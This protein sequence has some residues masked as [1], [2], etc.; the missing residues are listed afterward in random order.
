[1]NFN[2]LTPN[3]KFGAGGID[4]WDTD[5]PK[6]VISKSSA[7]QSRNHYFSFLYGFHV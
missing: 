2:Q 6:S 1:M 7:F 3:C 5:F 4:N